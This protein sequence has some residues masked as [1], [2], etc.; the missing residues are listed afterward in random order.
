MVAIHPRIE[1]L[2]PYVAGVRPEAG[3]TAIK[4]NQNE[5][6]YPASPRVAEALRERGPELL[7]EYP[8]SGCGRLV[9]A[10]SRAHGV[11]ASTILCGN[12]S[13]ELISLL[14]RT[15]LAEGDT[16][17]V[18]DPT[19]GLYATM[20]QIAGVRVREVPTDDEFRLDPERLIEADP[21]AVILANPNAPTGLYVEA[22][23]IERL[24]ERYRGLV[25]VDEAYVEFAPEG[26]SVVGLTRRWDN[27]LVLRT[28]SKAYGLSGA[29]IGFAVG[30]EQ[31]IRAMGKGKETFSVGAPAQLAAEAA[32]SDPAYMRATVSR[33]QRTHGEFRAALTRIGW[34][35][36]PSAANFLLASPPAGGLTAREHYD[37]LLAAGLY[38][39]HFDAPRLFDKLRIS[40]G[41]DADMR[42]L[43]KAL[44]RG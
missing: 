39:R 44:A 13:S 35:A 17:A 28:F 38:V 23:Q 12:G 34:K 31:L 9:E 4:L 33:I 24:L 37:R 29:R 41:T 42:T 21:Q 32:L 16:I 30:A 43:V 11:P 10:L 40:I 36:W 5:S 27:L 8:D 3:T 15:F 20:A 26:V 1:R 25:V 22:R 19:F 2:S 18:P 6:P 7:R 14:F